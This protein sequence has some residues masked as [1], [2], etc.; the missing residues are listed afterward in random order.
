MVNS[1]NIEEFCKELGMSLRK[2]RITENK[3]Q[4]EL[5]VMAGVSTKVIG[6]MERGDAS[7]SLARWLNVSEILGLLSTWQDVLQIKEDPFEKYDREQ[8]KITDLKKRRVRHKN[9]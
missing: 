3:T 8:K 7:V 9:K 6:R 2:A 1:L 4:K 5:G